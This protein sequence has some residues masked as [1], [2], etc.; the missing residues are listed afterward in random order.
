MKKFLALLFV[1]GL[2]SGCSVVKSEISSTTKSDLLS[3]NMEKR[4]EL[5]AVYLVQEMGGR[6]S[7]TEIKLHPEVL[8]VHTQ[9]DL[10]NAARN[11]LAIWIDKDSVN[12]ADKKWLMS[13]P[14]R[15]YP[16]AIVGYNN[17]VYSFRDLLNITLMHGPYVDW[18]KVKLEPGF[19][20]YMIREDSSNSR[21]L[22]L[23]G[24][25][26]EPT[27]QG[28]LDITNQLLENKFPS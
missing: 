10:E 4:I 1:V 2:L 12:T 6:L 20:V 25:E 28:I 3:N 7:E 8:V 16:V 19:S 14:Q 15:R 22:Y 13:E 21:S 9:K 24:Y 23:R 26:N 17:A 18:S 5:R 11:K 27:V